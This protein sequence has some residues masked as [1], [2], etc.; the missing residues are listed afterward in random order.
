MTDKI[1]M[2]PELNAALIRLQKAEMAFSES[3][4]DPGGPVKFQSP[5]YEA[6][7]ADPKLKLAYEAYCVLENECEEAHSALSQLL[8]DMGDIVK[9]VREILYGDDH[10]NP[11]YDANGDPINRS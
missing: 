1:E 9:T 3:P 8:V 11:M 6:R 7:R 4:F 5:E 2:T 10:G